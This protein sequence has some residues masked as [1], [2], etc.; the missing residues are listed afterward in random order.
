MKEKLLNISLLFV[1]DEEEPRKN[2]ADILKRRVVSFFVAENAEKALDIY[3]KNKP[4]IVLTDIQMPGMDGLQMLEKIKEKNPQVKLIV[5]T[6]FTNINYLLKSID[7]QVDGYIVKPVRKAKLLST[8]KKQTEIIFSQQK[9]ILQEKELAISEENYRILTETLEDIVVRISITGEMLYVSPAVKKFAG[10]SAEEETGNHVSKYFVYQ[11]ELQKGLEFI[12][13]EILRKNSGTFEFQFLPANKKPFPVELSYT[14]LIANNKVIAFQAVLRNISKRKESEE[15]IRS[16]N[17]QLQERN[18]ELDA[19]S[20]TVAHDLINPLST[21]MGFADLLIDQNYEI[22]DNE[23]LKYTDIIA[24][25]ARK[26]QQI[27]N[28]LLLFASV[29]KSEILLEEID[30]EAIVNEALIRLSPMIKSSKAK[31]TKPKVWPTPIG[32]APWIEEVLVNYLSNALKYGG[33]PP[34]IEIG[35][36]ITE[37]QNLSNKTI[38]FWVKDQGLGIS[39]ENQKLIFNKF[40][41]LHQLKTEGYGLGLSIVRRIIEK[42]GGKVG[43]E[44]E[45]G[46]GS[47]FYFTIPSKVYTNKNSAKNPKIT[48]KEP[49]LLLKNLKILIV[50]DEKSSELHLSLIT[51]KISREILTAKNGIEAVEICRT[52]PD[53]DLILMDI[54]MALMNGHAATRTI[55]EFNKE[56]II[57]AQTA[58]ALPGDKEEAIRAGCTDYITKP[59]DP[60]KLFMM[61]FKYLGD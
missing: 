17:L 19:F 41:R 14:P 25:N 32:F 10:Y 22:T 26:S 35:F 49:E 51:K 4:D 7:L 53:I 15:A 61:I 52:N 37:P 57:I 34:L 20:H 12:A 50:E 40:E 58:F 45:S 3:E 48:N 27:I 8:I 44:S 56:V 59:L 43:V 29:R 30:M 42:L 39:P 21:I 24:Q 6:A 18:E 5:M 46:N 2:I 13:K 38:R 47:M 1:E 28:S 11:E 9:L 16:K 31:I 60:E 23:R 55:R 33:S 54:K 36:E